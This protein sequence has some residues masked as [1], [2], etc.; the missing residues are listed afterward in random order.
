MAA[1]ERRTL[2]SSVAHSVHDTPL[3]TPHMTVPKE[4]AST[5]QIDRQAG[6]RGVG[7]GGAVQQPKRRQ[8]GRSELATGAGDVSQVFPA[9][10]S[11][12]RAAPWAPGV[13]GARRESWRGRGARRHGQE[14][15]PRRST[16]HEGTTDRHRGHTKS[17]GHTSGR[18]LATGLTAQ[19]YRKQ[20]EMGQ[21][22]GSAHIDKVT[23]DLINIL[24]VSVSLFYV[25]ACLA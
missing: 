16:A 2:I 14:R 12:L 10:S 25:S 9:L 5:E 11:V 8:T 22:Q 24:F 21:F 3:T 13:G 17:N 15:H 23:L 6:G 1:R 7:Q 19:T 18:Q 20:D 4:T